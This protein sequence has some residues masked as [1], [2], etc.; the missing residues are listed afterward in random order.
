MKK[1]VF[2]LLLLSSFFVLNALEYVPNE[3]IVKTKNHITVRS[4]S[5]GLSELDSYLS[6]FGVKKIKPI[7]HKSNNRFY[8]VILNSD[9]NKA[10][11]TDLHF[12]GVDY[13]Q[14]NYIN[15][16][17]SI[18][19]DP[20]FV[21]QQ[22]YDIKAPDAW[23]Y[24][25]GNKDIIIG[26][27]DSG[28]H[29]NHP[30]LTDNIYVNQKEIS[31]PNGVNL[32]TNNDNYI[33]L[34]ELVQYLNLQNLDL[35]NDGYINSWDVIA[36]NSPF[37][38]NIDDDEN[39]YTDDIL[40]WDFVDAPEL[41]AIA[42]G[43]FTDPDN[44]PEDENNHGTHVA[45]IMSAVA[46]NGIG[47]A[48]VNWHS[49]VLVAR[50]GFQT[51][52]SQ[53]YLQ[54]DDAAAAVIYAAD[55]GA[56][57]INAS[58]GD[59]V[60]SQ[61]IADACDYAY[62]KGC[63]V[64]VASGNTGD[65][66]VMYPAKLST[67]IAVG[68][69]DPQG[70]VASLTSWGPELDLLA[71]GINIYST[72]GD[73]I[74]SNINMYDY[75]SGTS[76]AAPFVTSSVALLLSIQPN[77]NFEEVKAKL[78]RSSHDIGTPGFD[79]HTGSGI[80]DLYKLIMDTDDPYIKITSPLPFQTISKSFP[81]IGS[82]NIPSFSKY[83]VMFSKSETPSGIDWCNV[84]Y[85][86]T[87]TPHYYYEP[88]TN[89]TIANFEADDTV[90]DG[91]YKI[92]IT[93]QSTS[94]QTYS[95]IASV[96]IDRSAPVI[97][98]SLTFL[99][100]RYEDETLKFFMKVA[101]DEPTNVKVTL[102]NPYNTYTANSSI[103]A[104]S[105][106]I[107]LPYMQNGNYNITLEATNLAGLK[108]TVT[109]PYQ[110][111]VINKTVDINSYTQTVI[112]N[113]KLF[114]NKTYDVDRNGKNDFVAVNPLST[115]NPEDNLLGF[116]EVDNSS[117]ITKRI[118]NYSIYPHDMGDTD[119][120]G[121]E[122]IG[123]NINGLGYHYENNSNSIYPDRIFTIYDTL[124]LGSNSSYYSG[125]FIDFNNDGIDDIAIKTF[126]SLYKLFVRD[127]DNV[128]FECNLYDNTPYGGDVNNLSL[129]LVCG[130]LDRDNS[131]DI[132]A[133]DT[134]GDVMVYEYNHGDTLL[135]PVWSAR[136]GFP[137]VTNLAIGNFRENVF[138]L[139]QFCVG[140]YYKDFLDPANSYSYF[141]FFENNGSD[142]QYIPF[143]S[144]GFTN[145][146]PP[147]Y[148]SAA[149]IDG[150][151]LDEL[152]ALVPPNIYIVKYN[153]ALGKFEAIW[154]GKGFAKNS[155]S[156]AVIP[157]TETQDAAILVNMLQNGEVKSSLIKKAEPF[158]GPDT[159]NN[160]RAEFTR[161]LKV[162]LSWLLDTHIDYYKIYR[163]RINEENYTVID[164][165]THSD[166]FIDENIAIGDTLYYRITAHSRMFHP[167]ESL[168]THEKQMIIDNP[169]NI[170]YIKMDAANR[171]KVLFDKRLANTSFSIGNFWVN[172]GMGYPVS[173]N[174][175]D[176]RCGALLT[177]VNTFP[178]P[179][180]ND[181][182]NYTI[183][184]SN[185][186]SYIGVPFF[187]SDNE[188]NIIPFEYSYDTTPPKISDVQII[189]RNRF[190]LVFSE[191]MNK[192]N[193]ENLGNYLLTPPPADKNNEIVSVVY[194]ADSN[195]AEITLKYK[196]HLS[197]NPYFLRINDVKDISG[198]LISDDGNKI[199]FIMNPIK[200]LSDMKVG[201]NPLHISKG[202]TLN[203]YLPL[204]KKST[205][206][207]FD[208]NGML[209]F[210]DDI[211]PL[212]EF[213]NFYIWD[214]RNLS[215]KKIGSGIYYYL[216]KM[217]NDLKKGKFTVIN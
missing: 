58:W 87:N 122:I 115:Q 59:Y 145:V 61:I 74:T 203:F 26:L 151:G 199:S 198:N 167:T 10:E 43:D 174:Q 49:K 184:L 66:G 173:V 48:G 18:P 24:T 191:S 96:I 90:L 134:D 37:L 197:N 21:Y 97:L 181:I 216:I 210:K 81:I 108:S 54:D 113:E 63:I 207:I 110:Y 65:A 3:I 1:I 130:L 103:T 38:N 172:N 143:G 28:I 169:P 186:K 208:I 192:T 158:S 106:S 104:S 132:V 78:H 117:I 209:I 135:L 29:L 161:D 109:L 55:N 166:S 126:Q 190:Y 20:G 17:Y 35:N 156:L 147:N 157:K 168:P 195:K 206:R 45:G 73:G 128:N 44:N 62:N 9:I 154:N 80:L 163:R 179:N 119:G 214:G 101:T 71:P 39:G 15:T 42:L 153:E 14:P 2:L 155:N 41:A 187:W 27:V 188:E 85:P 149:D 176:N 205:V 23:D 8:T 50:A 13:I 88:V 31:I 165:V 118:F 107:P 32:D 215:G 30:D 162:K 70:E 94:N 170:K 124:V 47:I 86:H 36:P 148:I 82:V 68:A 5:F 95:Y 159:P 213:K 111:A 139:K 138:H 25:Q 201:P 193:I 217:G 56:N 69:S 144:I 79:N 76:M 121:I 141:L 164:S 116:Y 102:T 12:S 34:P 211:E 77:L 137:N 84:I 92:K 93:V 200:N 64:C 100:E 140:G 127:H 57:V 133:G 40:G 177:F 175:V 89:D 105:Q 67:T 33:S 4:N 194:H 129:K 146:N 212:T 152:I 178:E 46:N 91:T 52:A 142:N 22:L 202:Q 98:D 171:L 189:D 51:T 150:D 131:A 75:Q 183:K 60:F 11:L 72:L 53:G 114:L 16:L 185:I 125:N 182:Q 19:N 83:S 196:A 6:N 204:G 180:Q 136:L 7:T 120:N 123:K 112:D 99:Q 160:F